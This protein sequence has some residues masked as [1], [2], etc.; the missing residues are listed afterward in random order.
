MCKQKTS[1][2]FQVLQA[3]ISVFWNKVESGEMNGVCLEEQLE[4]VHYTIF[5]ETNV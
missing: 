2:K 1:S 3:T 4:N 5:V